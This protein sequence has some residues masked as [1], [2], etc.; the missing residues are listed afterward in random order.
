MTGALLIDVASV[1]PRPAGAGRYAIELVSNLSQLCSG[2]TLSAARR[3]APFWE[4]ISGAKVA[5]GAPGRR[6]GRIL[7]ENV[8]LGY[9]LG[10]GGV[11]I[12]HGIHYTIPPGFGGRR[13]AT[14]HDMTMIEHP[15]W[16]ERIKVIYFSRAIRYAARHADVII[17][18]SEYTR[19]RLLEHFPYA[20]PVEVIHH[21]VSRKFFAGSDSG[22]DS[23][24]AARVRYVL[25]TGT[26]EP[27]KNLFNLV[28]AFEVLAEEDKDVRL[29]L[30]GQKGWKSDPICALI[31]GSRHSARIDV[32][33]YLPEKEMVETLRRASCVAY[34]SFAEGF[35]LPVL[36]AMA[37]GVPVVTSRDSVM[38][39]IAGRCAWLCDPNDFHDIAAK[40][41]AS[42]SGSAE[43]GLMVEVGIQRARSFDWAATA[44]K[45]LDVYRSV[46]F[47]SEGGF[48]Q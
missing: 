48:S 27:R 6:E 47:K 46:G 39:E 30:V 25:H 28:R 10:A 42:M 35:G 44:E 34:P 31:R 43:S 32:I 41:S 15:E 19:R 22:A 45:H 4:E 11:E 1:P 29:V 26:I 2:W 38:E 33:G 21:G 40:I 20:G 8:R 23:S 7:W 9:A 5:V 36:E 3:D 14:V 18:P 12:Y 13:I 17:V 16:H 24:A 37:V